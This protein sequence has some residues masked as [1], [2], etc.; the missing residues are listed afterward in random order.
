VLDTI[1]QVMQQA[2]IVGLGYDFNTHHAPGCHQDSAQLLIET[3]V[4][5]GLVKKEVGGF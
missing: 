4:I 2:A 3:Q 1:T 5:R